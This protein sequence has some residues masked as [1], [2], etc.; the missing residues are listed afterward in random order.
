MEA[1]KAV[2]C[3]LQTK[4]GERQDKVCEYTGCTMRS[5]IKKIGPNNILNC[6]YAD[7]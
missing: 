2:G 3:L 6:L 5:M 7:T 1:L 4:D